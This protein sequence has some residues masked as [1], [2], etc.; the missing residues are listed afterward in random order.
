M[1]L[2][3]V[4]KIKSGQHGRQGG[5]KAFPRG[6]PA[7][8][9]RS[10][11]DNNVLSMSIRWEPVR[12]YALIFV[13]AHHPSPQPV[14]ILSLSQFTDKGVEATKPPSEPGSLVHNTFHTHILN[15]YLIRFRSNL[16]LDTSVYLNSLFSPMFP[17]TIKGY[18]MINKKTFVGAG[19][20]AQY[21][22]PTQQI[23]AVWISSSKGSNPLVQIGMQAKNTNA[24]E[25]N[26]YKF[27][28]K[29]VCSL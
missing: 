11:S 4:G 19:E 13:S 18:T 9:S 24:W 23:T 5:S 21:P 6:P 25:R 2:K 27:K 12:L 17:K 20:M 10:H 16:G 28:T 15:Q 7:I 14:E 8:Y 26:T 29:K 1:A 22:A 3:L